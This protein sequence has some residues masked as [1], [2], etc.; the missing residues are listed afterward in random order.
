MF[1]PLSI[2]STDNSLVVLY[3]LRTSPLPPRQTN[4]SD[5]ILSSG[6][7]TMSL[8]LCPGNL[9][10]TPT[11][12]PYSDGAYRNTPS[13]LFFSS[14]QA[15]GTR[16]TCL[17]GGRGRSYKLFVDF[18]SGSSSYGLATSCILLF[19]PECTIKHSPRIPQSWGGGWCLS[20]A[21]LL[22][23]PSLP[24]LGGLGSLDLDFTSGCS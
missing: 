4:H 5:R 14:I 17:T 18:I 24:P 23:Q 16:I 11:F 8:W 9:K 20:E 10:C 1:K 12:L 21:P 6:R 15:H 19:S 22:H 2:Y 13:H 3:F 7:A